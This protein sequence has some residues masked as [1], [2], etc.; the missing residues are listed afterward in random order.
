MAERSRPK[1]V[2]ARQAGIVAPTPPAIARAGRLLRSG[3]LVALP[4]E[5][6]YGLAADA[7]NPRAVTAIFTAK[8][9]PRFNPLIIH[10]ARRSDAARLVHFDRRARALAAAFW[11]GPLTLVLR[12]R[13]QSPIAL[14]AGAG[15]DTLAI[16]M[17]DH[18][19]ARAAIR[20]AGRP[21]AAPSANR[22]GRVSPTTAAHVAAELGNRAALILDGGPCRVGIESTVLDISGPRAILLRPGGVSR[23]ALAAVIGAVA[24]PRTAATLRS[25]GLLASHYAPARPVRLNVRRPRA[26][27]AFLAFGAAP[28][29]TTEQL[30]ATRDLAEA[31]ANLFA[32]LRRA[33]RAPF[34][35]IAVAPIPRSG[36]GA[37][38]ND[39]LRRAAAPRKVQRNKT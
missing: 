11:P 10:V 35:A 16:R 27:E 12:R 34:R 19:V 7:T 8:R 6:V 25:P 33:D 29:G 28:A 5:T 20:A 39:R 21:L 31:A 3:Q 22:S 36:L 15:L 14:L 4:T 23:E 1:A 17:P 32:A 26:G 37:A 9:R 18:P 30:S 38:I 24:Q 13:A 2:K